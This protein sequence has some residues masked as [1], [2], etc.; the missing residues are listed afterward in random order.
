MLES[1][2]SD[3]VDIVHSALPLLALGHS[4]VLEAE[5][6]ISE[7]CA[8]GKEIEMLKHHTSIKSG[9]VCH[10]VPDE[11]LARGGLGET[12]YDPQERRLAATT[13]TDQTGKFALLHSEGNVLEYVNIILPG[14]KDLT[15]VP[16]FHIMH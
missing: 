3:H 10:F 7:Y 15:N 13:G 16:D 2:E 9:P 14:P 5:F 6:D 12:I 1:I 11:H 8:P 4:A